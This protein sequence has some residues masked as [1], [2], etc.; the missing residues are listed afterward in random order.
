MTE[1]IKP[2]LKENYEFECQ[3]KSI[4]VPLF[5]NFDYEVFDAVVFKHHVLLYN[6]FQI[7]YHL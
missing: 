6:F 7:W 3:D 2:L 1:G 5:H 4:F